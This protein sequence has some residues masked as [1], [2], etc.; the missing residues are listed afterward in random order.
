LQG[1]EG[2]PAS[3]RLVQVLRRP[4]DL[5]QVNHVSLEPAQAGFALAPDGFLS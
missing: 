4:M 1:R 2:G 5:V 3:E